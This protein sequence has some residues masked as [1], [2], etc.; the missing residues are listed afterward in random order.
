M[1]PIARTPMDRKSGKSMQDYYKSID[2]MLESLTPW[3]AESKRRRNR[4]KRENLVPGEAVVILG[5]GETASNPLYA[6]LKVVREG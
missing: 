1:L 6:G 3:V 5:K 2:K 4:I